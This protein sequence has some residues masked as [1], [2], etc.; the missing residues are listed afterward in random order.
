MISYIKTTTGEIFT[1]E[2]GVKET[3]GSVKERI[4]N[5]IGIPSNEQR[6]LFAGWNDD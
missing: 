2:V 5:Q 3:I 4:F 6:I 1:F